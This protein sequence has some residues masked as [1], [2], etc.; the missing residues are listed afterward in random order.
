MAQE[1]KLPDLGEG[2]EYGD[3]VQV[4]VAEGD[5]IKPEQTILEIETDKAVVEVPCPFGGRIAKL[6]VKPGEKVKVGQTLVTIE[7]NGA[8]LA[9]APQAPAPETQTTKAPVADVPSPGTAVPGVQPGPSTP[10]P[11]RSDDVPV[12]AGPAT[13]RL[14]RELG[15]ELRDVAAAKPGVRLTEDDVKE[16]VKL[17]MTAAAS[18]PASAAGGAGAM[19]PLPDF[20]QWGPIERVA[21]SSLQRKTAENLLASWVGPH[22]TQFDEADITTLEL[23]RKRHRGRT[24]EGG[25]KLTVT[26]FVI[27]AAALALKEFPQ[28][29]TSYDPARGELIY[30]RYYHVG[31]AVDTPAGLMVAVLRDVDTKRILDIAA[32]MNDLAERTRQRKITRDEMRGSTFTVTNLG[33]IGGTAFTPVVNYPEVAILGLARTREQPV[34]RDGQWATRLMLPLCL[35]YDHRI[36]NGADGA[37]FTRRLASLLEDPEML[38]LEG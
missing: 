2:V 21:L 37:R 33:G 26:A 38:L 19:P 16:Y 20:S 18:A 28:F 10:T 22:V 34:V 6:H 17:R 36:I 27:K 13:R 23:L 11:P 25:V 31:L 35:S 32:E 5:L 8:V 15:V 30:K 12:P 14:A 4:L 7:T 1:F 29:N 3:V 9:P 24:G